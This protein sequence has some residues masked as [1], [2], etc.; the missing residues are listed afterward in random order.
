MRLYPLWTFHRFGT[1]T[2]SCPTLK[3]HGLAFWPYWFSFGRSHQKFSF[4][5][6]LLL[7]GWR[8]TEFIWKILRIPVRPCIFT[9]ERL[10]ITMKSWGSWWNVWES[11]ANLSTPPLPKTYSKLPSACF[12]SPVLVNVKTFW[13]RQVMWNMSQQSV[14]AQRW[15]S[16]FMFRIC[17]NSCITCVQCI[18]QT[19]VQ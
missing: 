19:R 4:K 12:T 8:Y 10:D 1:I 6:I 2:Q 14:V 17:R 18:S 16:C 15:R 5:S 3:K 7:V 11:A 9:S 13:T